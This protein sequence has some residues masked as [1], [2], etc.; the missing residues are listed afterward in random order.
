MAQPTLKPSFQVYCGVDIAAQT[1]S[2]AVLVPNGTPQPLPGK[3]HN[4]AQ[5]K[6]DYAKLTQLLLQNGD[7][8]QAVLVVMEATGTYWLHLALYL[9]QAEFVVSVINPSQTGNF[10]R[11]LLLKVKN[12]QMDAQILARLA[13]V[14]QKRQL[15]RPFDILRVRL[16]I[17]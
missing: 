8:P 6:A 4:F 9:I 15:V 2:A 12:D 17:A 1:F 5:T 7:C 16:T 3:A 10:A 11:S 13:Y 14:H